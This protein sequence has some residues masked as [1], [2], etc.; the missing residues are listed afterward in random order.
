MVNG[1]VYASNFAASNRTYTD[2]SPAGR[3]QLVTLDTNE[4][5]A[6]TQVSGL[7]P[8]QLA[9]DSRGRPASATQ[10]T[11]EFSFTYDADGRVANMTDSLKLKHGFSYDADRGLL[12]TTLPDGLTINPFTTPMEILQ[13][14]LRPASRCMT[15][16]ITQ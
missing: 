1:R 12:T 8:T 15:F 13:P 6:T 16:P 14:S 4:R 2:T 5:T 7:L 9:Y 11:R 10:G 3:Q